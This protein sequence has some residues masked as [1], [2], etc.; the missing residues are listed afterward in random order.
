MTWGE[1]KDVVEG[2][3]VTDEMDVASIEISIDDENEPIVEI[4]NDEVV[5]F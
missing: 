2:K 4:N 1:F 3:G 5:I